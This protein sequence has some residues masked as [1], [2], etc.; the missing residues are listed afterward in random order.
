MELWSDR[1]S[2]GVGFCR[3][4]GRAVR[5][6][7]KE[8][9]NVTEHKTAQDFAHCMYEL[10]TVHYPDAETIRMVLDNLSSHKP[11][12]LYEVFAPEVARDVLRRLEFHFAPKHASWLNM[13][14]IEIGVLGRQCLD[15]RIGDRD[16]LCRE[17]AQWQRRR[18]AEGARV[19]W[20]LD[21][22]V[23]AGN[24]AAS[25][26]RRPSLTSFRRPETVITT[27]QRYQG[28]RSRITD[29][30]VHEQINACSSDPDSGL[31]HLLAGQGN[32]PPGCRPGLPVRPGPEPARQSHLVARHRPLR[33]D[34]T[35]SQQTPD[36]KSLA[37]FHRK[38]ACRG[39]YLSKGCRA[40]PGRA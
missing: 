39:L 9:V 32:L 30:E 4:C 14:E 26:P 22:Q 28:N 8:H 35:R 21:T 6:R 7:E 40:V 17:V 10:A 3:K 23:T 13:V 31:H 33:R 37:H 20:L 2:G 36:P 29:R 24:W 25:T 1:M 11:A 5:I 16:T 15:R 27:V 12:A 34:Q 18:N 38:G 19:E